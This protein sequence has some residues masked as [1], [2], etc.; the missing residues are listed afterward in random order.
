M[1]DYKININEVYILNT[2]NLKNIKDWID[3][4]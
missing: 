3:E 1:D 4:N 2:F